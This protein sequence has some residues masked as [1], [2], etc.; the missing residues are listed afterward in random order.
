MIKS[1]RS[2]ALILLLGVACADGV[3]PA[4]GPLRLTVN[5]ESILLRVGDTNTVVFRL[6][7]VGA[8]TLRLTFSD[9]CQILPYVVER[10]RH[11]VV[12]PAGGGWGCFTAI[13][14]L[15]LTPGASRVVPLLLR[16]GTSATTDGGEVRLPRGEYY[17]YARL[18]HPAY[19]LR[20]TLV[21]IDVR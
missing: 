14:S 18:E 3:A 9:S 8:E 15:T 7:N 20:S 6:S 12:H 4:H 5:T 19:A 13:T 11:A 1:H 10:R 16:G 2:I 17:A 21:T